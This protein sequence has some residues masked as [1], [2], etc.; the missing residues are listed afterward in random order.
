M[1]SASSLRRRLYRTVA[2]SKWDNPPRLLLDRFVQETARETKG[3]ARILDAGAGECRHAEVFSHCAYVACDRAV[4]DASWDYGRLDVLAD[5]EALP[6]RP[7]S[8]DAI[9]CSQTLEHVP[10]PQHALR[11]MSA[12]LKPNG[13]LILT[14]PFLGDPLHQEPYDF[15][16]YTP[17]ALRRLLAGAGL[18]PLV[19]APIG[20]I[21]FLL[22]CYLWFFVVYELS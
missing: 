11:E 15:Y 6:F 20:G 16:R 5:L 18:R 7:E 21:W 9:L 19:L 8:F 10:E 12:V 14:V 22:C 2:L 17:Y 4:G 13:R 1:C 3:G